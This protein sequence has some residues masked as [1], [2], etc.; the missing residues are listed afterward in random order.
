MPAAETGRPRDS[1]VRRRADGATAAAVQSAAPRT[2][3]LPVA[4]TTADSPATRVCGDTAAVRALL[5]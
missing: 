3:P 1:G 5:R 4:D 2:R